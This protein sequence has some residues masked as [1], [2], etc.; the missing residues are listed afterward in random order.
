MVSIDPIDEEAPTIAA[1][2]AVAVTD[3]SQTVYERL[4]ELIV[5]LELEPGSMVTES[6]LVARLGTSRSSLREA[7]VRTIDTGL[8]SVIPRTGIAIA[9][10]RLLDVQNVYEARLVIETTLVRL[11]AERASPDAIAAVSAFE[12]AGPDDPSPAAMLT[13]DRRLHQAIGDLARNELLAR[14]LR[15]ALLT[16]ARVWGLYHQLRSVDVP[17]HLSHRDI[18]SALVARDPDAAQGAMERYLDG[19]RGRLSAVFWPQGGP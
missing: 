6:D 5:T 11:A 18:V 8:A 15:I 2:A 13:F 16:S 14:A 4:V 3:A 17:E 9:P 12:R 1:P 19:S 10:V 7:V